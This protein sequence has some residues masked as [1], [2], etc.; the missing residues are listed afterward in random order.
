MPQNVIASSRHILSKVDEDVV[1]YCNLAS[2]S[3]IV[4]IFLYFSKVYLHV[5]CYK[6]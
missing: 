5:G 3:W 6:K 4:R 2:Y 1:D